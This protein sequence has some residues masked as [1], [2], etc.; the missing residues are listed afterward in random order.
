MRTLGLLQRN[1]WEHAAQVIDLYANNLFGPDVEH[2]VNRLVL[3]NANAVA[4]VDLTAAVKQ[5]L[6]EFLSVLLNDYGLT[7]KNSLLTDRTFLVKAVKILKAKA[8]LEGRDTIPEDLFVLK[9]LTTFRIPEEL[10]NRIEDIIND[11]LR[12]KLAPEDGRC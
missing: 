6:L 8:V 11:L 12:K 1:H 2:K 4:K 7:D 5:L 9:Y 3:D 10:H